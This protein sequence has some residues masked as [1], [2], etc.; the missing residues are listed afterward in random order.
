M[1]AQQCLKAGPLR[2]KQL[3][4]ALKIRLLSKT[5]T[6][7]LIRYASVIVIVGKHLYFSS[8]YMYY[9]LLTYGF[10]DKDPQSE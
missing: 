3:T 1:T 4:N 6:L 10:A 5:S 9:R 8:N 7:Y 2:L